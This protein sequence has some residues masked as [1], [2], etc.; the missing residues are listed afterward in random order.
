MLGFRTGQ[1]FYNYSFV[2]LLAR[3][4][5][6]F[7]HGTLRVSYLAIWAAQT[8]LFFEVEDV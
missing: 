3:G 8:K 2:L 7:V 5:Y 4:L 6:S 1:L